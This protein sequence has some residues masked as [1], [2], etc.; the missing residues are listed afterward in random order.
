MWVHC[1]RATAAPP[2]RALLPTEESTLG[3]WPEAVARMLG[4]CAHSLSFLM[5]PLE[6]PRLGNGTLPL[7]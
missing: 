3:W 2:A 7:G 4:I 6:H 1:A 5:Y